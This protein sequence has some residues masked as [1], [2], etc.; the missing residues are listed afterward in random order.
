[1]SQGLVSSLFMACKKMQMDFQCQAAQIGLDAAPYAA[2]QKLWRQD[3]VT[4]TELGEK[5]F[6]KA[7]TITSLIDRMERDGLVQRQRDEED[8]RVV[9]IY[10]TTRARNL[11]GKFPRFEEHCIE[12]IKPHFTQE[13]IQTLIQLLKKLEQSL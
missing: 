6:L 10:L 2:L 9:K 8:R 3:G 4:I 13:E 1:M 5:L 12:K 11:K 7:S